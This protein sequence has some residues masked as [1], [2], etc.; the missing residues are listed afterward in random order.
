MWQKFHN[1]GIFHKEFVLPGQTVNG[2]LYWNVLEAIRE[3]IRHKDPDKGCNNSWAVNHDNAPAHMLFVVQQFLAS[4]HESPPPSI[5]NGP[6]PWDFL[7]FPK[8]KLKLKG[9]HFDSSDP[10]WVT[11]HDEDADMKRLPEALLIIEIPLNSP[12]QYQRGLL[13]REWR[14]IEISVSG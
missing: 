10:D 11:E 13:R 9:Q 14:Q 12:Y 8:M 2:K 4:T 6:H 5:L 3:N 7:L 1:E